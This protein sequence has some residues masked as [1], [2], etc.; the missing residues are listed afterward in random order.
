MRT[1]IEIAIGY[2]IIMTTSK[3]IPITQIIHPINPF[4]DG[5]GRGWEGLYKYNIDLFCKKLKFFGN[6]V[7]TP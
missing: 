7:T 6:S 4:R 3:I 5:G 1:P 2:H